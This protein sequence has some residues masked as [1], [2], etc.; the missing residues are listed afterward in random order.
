[1]LVRD[2]KSALVRAFNLKNKPKVPLQV[3]DVDF[4]NVQLE[5]YNACNAKVTLQAKASSVNFQGSVVVRYN[6]GRLDQWCRNMVVPG[7][8]SDYATNHAVITKLRQVYGLPLS[9]DDVAQAAIPATGNI[10]LTPKVDALG[11]LFTYSA[12]LPFETA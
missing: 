2:V 10:R 12:D 4:V 5:L 1:M 11:W 9:T 3:S 7:K 6:R 8:R